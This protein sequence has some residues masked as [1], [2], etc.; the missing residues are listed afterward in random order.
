M[1]GRGGGRGGGKEGG[2]GGSDF[3]LPDGIQ[4]YAA[5]PVLGLVP[6]D[7]QHLNWRS[8]VRPEGEQ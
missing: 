4:R 5:V 3:Y 8:N 6:T 7:R 1:V 2:E